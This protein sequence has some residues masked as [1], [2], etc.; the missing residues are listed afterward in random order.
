VDSLLC[1]GL[2]PHAGDLGSDVSADGAEAFCKR[3]IDATLD[4]AAAYKPNAAFFEVFG[5][6][7]SLALKRVINYIPKSIPVVLDAKRGDISTTAEAY[8]E[9]AFWHYGAGSVTINPYMGADSILPFTKNPFK[10]AWIL[11]KTSNPGSA[12]LQTLGVTVPGLSPD[13]APR[14]LFE[15]VAALAASTHEWGARDNVGLVVGATDVAALRSVRSVAPDVWILAPGLGVQGG[16]LAA[17]VAAGVR[18]DGTGVLFPVS[19]GLSRAADVPAAARQLRDEINAAR[20]RATATAGAAE[21]GA[22][23]TSTVAP[24]SICE[25]AAPAAGLGSEAPTALRA[26]Q[27]AF[28]DIAAACGALRFGSFTLKSGRTSPYFFNAGALCSGRALRVL[29]ESYAAAIQGSGLAFDML[30]GPAYKGIPLATIAAAALA[31]LPSEE[32]VDVP[33][34]YNRKEAKDH[35]EGGL[36]VGAPVVGQRVLIV[37]DVITAGTAI[38]EAIDII[39]GA[40][41]TP[42]GVVVGLDRQEVATAAVPGAPALSAVQQ[43]EATYGI[44]V[45]AVASLGDLIAYLQEAAVAGKKLPGLASASDGVLAPSATPAGGSDEPTLQDMLARVQ[46]YRTEYGVRPGT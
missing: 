28:L 36:L 12:E 6:A 21:A 3:L 40:G 34:A 15:H 23:A 27:R 39:K 35:G 8:A 24:A 18:F 9:T 13:S 11:C 42:V 2:D 7:G 30:F 41:G 46:A 26:H 19:R 31:S 45:L 44:P 5:A 29:G 1:V 17:A 14:R 43:V 38:G 20:K 37:D 25:P 32:A 16:D 33:V 10:A 4:F 22:G